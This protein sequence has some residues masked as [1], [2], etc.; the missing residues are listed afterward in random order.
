MYSLGIC[1]VKFLRFDSIAVKL[2]FLQVAELCC[3][4]T[5]ITILALILTIFL[6]VNVFS[7]ELGL[8]FI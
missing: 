8:S 6:S 7:V 2:L 1:S 5:Q 4:V 3:D